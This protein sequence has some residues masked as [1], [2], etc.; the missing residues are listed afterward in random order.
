M[1]QIDGVVLEEENDIDNPLYNS[2]K[3]AKVRLLD[4]VLKKY[5]TII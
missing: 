1:L 5:N 3:Y 2:K 4:H